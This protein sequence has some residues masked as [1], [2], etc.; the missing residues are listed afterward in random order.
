MKARKPEATPGCRFRF[1]RRET[2]ELRRDLARSKRDVR[3]RCAPRNSRRRRYVVKA[4]HGTCCDERSTLELGGSATQLWSSLGGAQISNGPTGVDRESLRNV[5]SYSR[6]QG[7]A[8]QE[9]CDTKRERML[10]SLN[11]FSSDG[12]YCCRRRKR[13]TRSRS[14][15]RI[16]WIW[17]ILNGRRGG[18]TIMSGEAWKVRG[19]R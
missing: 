2:H 7:S 19:R 4:E 12:D 1:V 16:R 10:L 5:G 18:M 15:E 8:F 3:R 14:S 6:S 11:D 17:A 13:Q 9:H